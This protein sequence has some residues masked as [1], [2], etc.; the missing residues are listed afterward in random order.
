[1]IGVMKE[2]T[3]LYMSNILKESGKLQAKMNRYKDNFIDT[4]AQDIISSLHEITD[5]AKALQNVLEISKVI[6]VQSQQA[7][8]EMENVV[9]LRREK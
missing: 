7:V 4:E 8:T 1:M 3:S 9:S 6:A 2:S 5:S